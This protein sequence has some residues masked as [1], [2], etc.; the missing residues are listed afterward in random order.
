MV[1]SE[2]EKELREQLLE[3]REHLKN[4]RPTTAK[5]AKDLK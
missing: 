2:T 1:L 5:M 3:K 4:V